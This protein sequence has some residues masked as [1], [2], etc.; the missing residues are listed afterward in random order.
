MAELVTLAEA[1][2]HL[3]LDTGT[4]DDA[5]LAVFVPAISEAVLNWLKDEWRAYV[6]ELDSAGDP[7]LDTAGDPIPE[8]DSDG[9]FTPKWSVKAAVLLE[10]GNAYRNREGEGKDNV[11]TP[12]AGWGYVLNK[13]STAILQPLRKS[14]VA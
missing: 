8:V 13:A 10:L 12:D 3:R 2:N 9:E 6:P 4:A 7:I 1:R 5:W 14:T 11:V